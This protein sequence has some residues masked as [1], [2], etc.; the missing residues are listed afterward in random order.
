MVVV[1]AL[2]LKQ[3]QS[4][5]HNKKRIIYAI[6]VNRL[7]WERERGKEWNRVTEREKKKKTTI[8]T[9]TMNEQNFSKWR[10]Y[11]G[12]FFFLLFDSTIFRCWCACLSMYRRQ[13]WNENELAKCKKRT[14]F[15]C[16][17]VWTKMIVV[18]ME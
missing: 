5:I 3:I 2:T 12:I 6:R 7:R 11:L 18:Q 8:T 4:N 15:I 16:V 17:C 10:L 14:Q 13:K 1:Y 9:T